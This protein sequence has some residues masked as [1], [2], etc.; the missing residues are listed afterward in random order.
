EGFDEWQLTVEFDLDATERDA[1]LR[2]RLI[3]LA[4]L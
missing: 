2:G 1:E 4:R 3:T